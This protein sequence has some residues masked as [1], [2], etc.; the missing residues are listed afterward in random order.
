MRFFLPLLFILFSVS[1]PAQSGK[2][3]KIL[4]ESYLQQADSAF[5][6]K[7]YAKAKE[8][9][10]LA[11]GLKPKEEFLKSKISECDQRAAVQSVEYRKLVKQADSCFE[12]KKWEAAKNLY[13][14]ATA[15]KPTEPYARDQAKTCNYNIL[16]ANA[17]AQK[18][19]ESIRLGDSCFANKSWSCAKANYQA[20]LNTRPGEKYPAERIKTC[21]TK[22]NTVVNNEQYA[23]YISDAD[24]K[25]DGGNFSYAKMLYELALGAKPDSQ[26][27][28]ERIKLCEAKMKE[29]Q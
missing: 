29:G 22:I 11:L 7:D 5:V 21:D 6:Q 27:A 26:Y 24:A 28:Q 2:Q 19:S 8:Q 20:A 23:I 4:Y 18:Y 10:K 1:V 17:I 3:K 16:A 13:L 14:Q 12:K 15:V 25:F 9:Y